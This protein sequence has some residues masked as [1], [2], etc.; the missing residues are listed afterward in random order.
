M[1][2][3]QNIGS[4]NVEAATNMSNMFGG[5]SSAGN[6]TFNNGGSDSIKNWKPR[7]CTNMTQM[8][9]ASPF[10]QP[11]GDWDV[12]NVTNM[13]DMFLENSSL[14][15][16]NYNNILTGWDDRPTHAITAFASG[17]GSVTIVTSAGHGLTTNNRVT[18]SGTT[19]YNG[20]HIITVINA[21]SY[22]IPIAFV[23]DDATGTGRQDLRNS[24][25]FNAGTAQ[26]S[27]GAPA[28]AR[29][30]IISTYTWTITDGGEE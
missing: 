15:T 14:N 20:Q 3:N 7:R 23:A 2:F 18:I 22:S 10:N 30:N 17:G 28:T 19:N 29:A 9:R 13:T 25:S 4:W 16:T 26:Y 24:V 1:A 5:N 27:A 11:I 6:Q 21:D 8:F 12:S